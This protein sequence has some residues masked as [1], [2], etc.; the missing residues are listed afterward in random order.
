LQFSEVDASLI[1]PCLHVLEDAVPVW[2]AYQPDSSSIP[3]VR[4]CSCFDVHVLPPTPSILG[5]LLL[6]LFQYEGIGVY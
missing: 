4:R 6:G 1:L 5:D 2:L 3:E